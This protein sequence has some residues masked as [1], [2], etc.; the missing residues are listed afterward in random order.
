[1]EAEGS[2][3]CSQEPNLSNM[4]P[5]N[6][7]TPTSLRPILTASSYIRL[8]PPICLFLPGVPGNYA[9]II[10]SPMRATCPSHLVPV[11]STP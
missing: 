8:G 7:L 5:V 11:T 6:I 9:L 1:M 2:L 4:D 3:Q 10:I